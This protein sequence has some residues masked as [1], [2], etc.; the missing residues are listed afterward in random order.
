[1]TF[2]VTAVIMQ[3]KYLISARRCGCPKAV[4]KW[5]VH[6]IFFSSGFYFYDFCTFSTPVLNF[7]ESIRHVTQYACIRFPLFSRS[8]QLRFRLIVSHMWYTTNWCQYVGKFCLVGAQVNGNFVSAQDFY[9][10][11]SVINHNVWL[12]TGKTSLRHRKYDFNGVSWLEPGARY[13]GG[14]WNLRSIVYI[15]NTNTY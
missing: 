7:V 13:G 8:I 11:Q 2:P 10:G 9:G 14:P 4:L 6:I 15:L 5:S 3:S 12:A 1:M